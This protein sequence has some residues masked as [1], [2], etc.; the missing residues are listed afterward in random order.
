[1]NRLP[2]QVEREKKH[3]QKVDLYLDVPSNMMSSHHIRYKSTVTALSLY[4][5]DVLKPLDETI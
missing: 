1:M 5:G 4:H 2:Y 3:P